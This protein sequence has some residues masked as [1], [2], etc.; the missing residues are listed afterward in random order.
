MKFG[1]SN[2]ILLDEFRSYTM[3]L[4][5]HDVKK[6][7]SKLASFCVTRKCKDFSEALYSAKKNMLEF[8]L[9]D[10]DLCK[11]F[12]NIIYYDYKW[13]CDFLTRC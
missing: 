2:Q 7:E 5:P 12:G 1:K 11:D 8:M 3:L 4:T 9:N 6:V 10:C 13:I